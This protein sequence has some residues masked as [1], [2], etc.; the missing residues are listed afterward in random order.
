MTAPVTSQDIVAATV[1]WLLTKPAVTSAV[2][3]FTIDGRQVP[4]LFQYRLWTPIEGTSNTAAVITH[5]G[6]WATPNVHNTM[7]FPRI[8]LNLWADPIRDAGNNV[9]DLPEVQ[10]RIAWVFEQIDKHLHITGNASMMWGD[11]RVMTSV[12]LTEPS[13]YVVPDGDGLVRL[14]AYYAITQG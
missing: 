10:R 6:G 5:E 3:M 1:K 2:S 13:I 9:I 4:G 11:V 12:R 14:Q 7:R 8:L